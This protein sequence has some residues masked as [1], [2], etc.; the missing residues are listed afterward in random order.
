MKQ[1]LLAVAVAATTAVMYS[2]TS[3]AVVTAAKAA[4]D[5]GK[6]DAIEVGTYAIAAA[7]A[8]CLILIG[9]VLVK[10]ILKKIVS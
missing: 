6:A 9:I 1:K 8:V 3:S 7:A 5:E 4:I 2:Q 10:K